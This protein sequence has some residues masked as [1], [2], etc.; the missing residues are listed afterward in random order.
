MPTLISREMFGSA[1]SVPVLSVLYMQGLATLL[2]PE[3]Q[4]V[5]TRH[6]FVAAECVGPVRAP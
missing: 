4:S 3:F 6:F 1:R 5:N 2:R